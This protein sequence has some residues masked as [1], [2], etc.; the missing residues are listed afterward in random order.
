MNVTITDV[1]DTNLISND[2]ASKI[3]LTNNLIEHFAP[4]FYEETRTKQ[5]QYSSN[6]ADIKK[7]KN[8]IIETKKKLLAFQSDIELETVKNQI[9]K[10]IELLNQIDVLYGN[11]KLLVQKII[12]SLDSQPKS[13][14]E[15]KLILLQKLT[16]QKKDK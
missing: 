8:I 12:S 5:K 6:V 16:S 14:L 7:L 13:E 2:Q 15:K 3:L 4:L 11:S 1:T 9:L 10:E